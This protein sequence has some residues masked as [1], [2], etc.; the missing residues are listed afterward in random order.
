MISYDLTLNG[1]NLLG[2]DRFSIAAESNETVQLRF[3]FDRNWRI[4]DSKAA[5]FRDSRRKYYV[6]DI[7]GN[8]VKVPWEVLRNDNGFDLA[9]VAYD[10]SMVLTSKR[11]RISVS[12]SLLPEICSQLSPTETLFDRIRTESRAEAY[13]EYK[14]EIHALKRTHA[15]ELRELGEEFEEERQQNAAA[16][17]QKE[18]EIEQLNYQASCVRNEHN[19]ELSA[20]RTELAE[21]TVKADNWDLIDTALGYK[22]ISNQTLWSGE[23]EFFELP[24]LNTSSIT[25]FTNGNFSNKLTKIG[26]DLSS[27]TS[28]YEMFKNKTN[29][30]ELTLKNAEKVTTVYCMM[31][32]CSSL[33][34]ADL[35][36]L[37]NCSN[38]ISLFS[39]CRSLE[40]VTFNAPRFANTNTVFYNCISLKEINTVLDATLCNSFTNT[41][42]NCVSLEKIRFKESTI[43]TSI[44]FTSCINLTKESLFSI[45]NG[46]SDEAPSTVSF[47]AGAFNNS[48]TAQER[49]EITELI[50]NVKGWTLSLS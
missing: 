20:L 47:A 3:H 45:A 31:Q 5:V 35:G 16:L 13:L 17:A 44:N 34:R 7:L 48:L 41:F 8:C 50:E 4:F 27:V 22:T 14:N 37:S 40:S 1:Q 18:S 49:E 12:Q 28:M 19:A 9:V 26:L 15:D 29:L 30:K 32:N 2:S 25:G 36:T 43:R 23:Q 24:M 42:F 21:K 46:L 39:E 33:V 11:V 10:N 6:L 38:F